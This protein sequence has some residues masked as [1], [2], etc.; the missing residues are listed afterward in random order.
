MTQACRCRQFAGSRRTIFRR[1][2]GVPGSIGDPHVREAGTIGGSVANNDPNADYPGRLPWAWRDHHHLQAQ[3]SGRR[4]FH[5]HVLDRARAGRDHHQDFIPDRQESR[6]SEVQASRRPAL[7]WSACSCR[8]AASDIRVA[9]TGAGSNGVFRVKEF[10]EALK[11]RFAPKSLEGAEREA[12]R[13]Q[14]RHPCR[15]GLSRAPDRRAGAARGRGRGEAVTFF[16]IGAQ[17]CGESH[18]AGL[19]A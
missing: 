10:E 2:P 8:S 9:V 18:F 19:G 11:K 17:S 6:L 4:I 12:R 1:L 5:R 14:Q 16:L 7:R 13:P 3:N 15:R